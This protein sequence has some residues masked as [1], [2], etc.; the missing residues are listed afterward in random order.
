MKWEKNIFE[1]KKY[2]W[3][4]RWRILQFRGRNFAISSVRPQDSVSIVC[5]FYQPKPTVQF[6][7]SFGSSIYSYLYFIKCP[8]LALS[9][10]STTLFPYDLRKTGQQPPPPS[11]RPSH[12]RRTHNPTFF[13]NNK[14]PNSSLRNF[15]LIKTTLRRAI[16]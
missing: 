3:V 15:S 12:L 11:I 16:R 1:K 9:P 5:Y 6:R 14:P 2:F 7:I 8:K 4:S 10:L 13:T